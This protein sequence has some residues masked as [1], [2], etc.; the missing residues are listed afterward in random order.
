MLLRHVGEEK[1]FIDSLKMILGV[2]GVWRNRWMAAAGRDNFMKKR[3]WRWGLIRSR[4]RSDIGTFRLVLVVLEIFL[5]LKHNL[6]HA[7]SKVGDR[8]L[9]HGINIVCVLQHRHCPPVQHCHVRIF[10]QQQIKTSRSTA[11]SG[12]MQRCVPTFAASIHVC[13][14]FQQRL[15]HLH[16]IESCSSMNRSVIFVSREEGKVEGVWISTTSSLSAN[17]DSPHTPYFHHTPV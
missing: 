4:W 3:G 17:Y 11:P 16:M 2:G 14:V 13:P 7:M 6:L 12:S 8:V 15:H 1:V 9:A 10:L 5:S